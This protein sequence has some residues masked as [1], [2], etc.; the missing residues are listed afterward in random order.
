MISHLG[1]AAADTP[2]IEVAMRGEPHLL[3]D[4]L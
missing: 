1:L 4:R 3:L 2:K